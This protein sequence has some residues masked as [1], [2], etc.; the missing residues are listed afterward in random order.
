MYRLLLLFLLAPLLTNAQYTKN[1]DSLFTVKDY[2]LDISNTVRSKQNNEK[3][4]AKLGELIRSATSKKAVFD[5]NLTKIIKEDEDTDRLK[6]MFN[7]A[8]QSMVLYRS[9]LLNN[10][11]NQT[12]ASY[13][14]EKLSILIFKIYFYCD[15]AQHQQLKNLKNEASFSRPK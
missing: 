15:S 1:I 14:Y 12:E 5:R 10:F 13:L 6:S 7:L 2:L 3:K 8:M 11:D 9:D 4:I